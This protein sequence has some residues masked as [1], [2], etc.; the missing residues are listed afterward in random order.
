MRTIAQMREL[1]RLAKILGF[2]DDV[3]HW[4]QQIA[5]AEAK[6]DAL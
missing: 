1:L 6:A 4:T 3:E 2:T 5:E